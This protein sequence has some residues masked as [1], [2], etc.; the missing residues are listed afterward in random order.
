MVLSKYDL[1]AVSTQAP[2]H[3]CLDAGRDFHD[4][5]HL[6]FPQDVAL[7]V[8]FGEQP[9]VTDR[10]PDAGHRPQRLG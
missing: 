9:P 8:Q 5:I 4:S 10:H 1:N 3:S 6:H 2:E 7:A